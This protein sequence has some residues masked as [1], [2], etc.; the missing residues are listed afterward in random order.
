MASL[1][2]GSGPATLLACLVTEPA[3]NP[4]AR[5]P[6]REDANVF[7]TFASYPSADAY[8]PPTATSSIV[9]H[10]EHLLLEPTRR[11]FLRHR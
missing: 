6:V 4:V 2:E 9:S 10:R 11:S 5:L 1:R 8:E 7:V 3:R